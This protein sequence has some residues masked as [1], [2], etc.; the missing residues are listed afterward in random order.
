MADTF[1]VRAVRGA[2]TIE[3]DERDHLL[4]RT[5][6]LIDAVLDRNALTTDELISI[7]FT[8]TPD[9]HAA[10]PAEAARLGG[11]T[12]VPLMC[13]QELAIDTGIP[14]C[15]RLLAHVHTNKSA[16]ELRHVYLHGARQLRTDLPE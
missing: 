7:W 4:D 16:Q 1:R 3:V 2:T 9:L 10:F 8:M 5:R 12:D 6:E 13:A 14:R 11:I 15:I